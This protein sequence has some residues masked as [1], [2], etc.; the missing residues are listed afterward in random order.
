MNNQHLLYPFFA[1]NRLGRP[2]QALGNATGGSKGPRF[3][4]GPKQVK[5]GLT[6]RC[7]YYYSWSGWQDRYVYG[8]PGSTLTA[9]NQG[10]TGPLPWSPSCGSFKQSR[11]IEKAIVTTIILVYCSDTSSTVKISISNDGKLSF[12]GSTQLSFPILE[13]KT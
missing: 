12:Y 3:F 11:T 1:T 9:K 10:Y 2:G 6:L 4:L 7:L 8:S 5:K 13:K